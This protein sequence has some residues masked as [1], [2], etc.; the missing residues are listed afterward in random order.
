M[1]SEQADHSFLINKGADKTVILE[2]PSLSYRSLSD[3]ITGETLQ[4]DAPVKLLAH[5]GRWLRFEN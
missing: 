2:T 4:P 3:A 5:D 1:A